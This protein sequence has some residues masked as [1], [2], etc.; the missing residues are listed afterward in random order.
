MQHRQ[1][2]FRRGALLRG[3]HVH[4]DASAVVHHGNGVVS[5][6]GDVNLVREARHGFIDRIVDDFPDEVVQAHLS[7]RADIHSLNSIQVIRI[8]HERRMRRI[9]DLVGR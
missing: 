4:G 9:H 2:N 5:V 8:N 6:H 3:M 7:S 1:H